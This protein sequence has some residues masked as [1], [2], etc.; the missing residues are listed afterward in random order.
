VANL[1]L[2]RGYIFLD[3]GNTRAFLKSRGEPMGGH[4]AGFLTTVAQNWSVLFIYDASGYVRDDEKDKLD[5]NR[6]L[7]SIRQAAVAG[8]QERQRRGTPT[9]EVL[10]WEL[11]P[12]Y[13]PAAHSLDWAV[14]GVSQGQPVVNYNARLLGRRGVMQAILIVA[15]D[16]LRGTLPLFRNVLAGF[17]FLPGQKYTEYRPGDKAAPAGLS[18]LVVGSPAGASAATVLAWAVALLA[19]V[20]AALAVLRRLGRQAAR[21]RK[22]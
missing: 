10:G 17:S 16:K 5:P 14:R 21:R 1:L 7:E 22:R 6:L 11:R 2:P 15:P 4:E 8:N 12:Q 13:D 20:G 9:V 19:L 18:A 3:A